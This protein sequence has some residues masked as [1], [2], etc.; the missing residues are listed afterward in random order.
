M[1]WR[2]SW[3]FFSNLTI[4]F[5][6]WLLDTA[7]FSKIPCLHAPLD[8]RSRFADK[9]HRISWVDPRSLDPSLAHYSKSV[10]S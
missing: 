4:L 2:R 1:V 7:G 8:N 10:G 6:K 3:I 5:N 9:Y